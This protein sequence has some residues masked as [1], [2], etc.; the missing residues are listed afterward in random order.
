MYFIKMF[1][2]QWIMIVLEFKLLEKIINKKMKKYK[3]C[4]AACTGSL[5]GCLYLL[6]LEKNV[7]VKFI[8]LLL[9]IMGTLKIAY[10]VFNKKDK[11]I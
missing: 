1:L 5:A 3:M 7:I 4:L 11:N 2:E 8:F 6:F 10:G 9:T